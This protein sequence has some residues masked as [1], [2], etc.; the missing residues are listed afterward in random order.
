MN[1]NIDFPENRYKHCFSVGKVMYEYSKNILKWPEKKAIEMFILGNMH[2]IGYELDPDPFKHEII[3]ADNIN[4]SYKYYNEIKYHSEL[5]NIYESE[6]LDLLYFADMVVDGYGNI[7]TFEERLLDL[8][9]R[10][11]ENSKI[12][13]ESEKIAKYLIKKGFYD[14][15]H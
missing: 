2:D 15:K 11:G 4:D 5:Q 3:I 13:I 8:K 10:H 7:C 1:I 14:I 12:Y 6:E 9:N